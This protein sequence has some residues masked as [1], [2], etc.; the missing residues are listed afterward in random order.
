MH[1][2]IFNVQWDIFNTCH[3]L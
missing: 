2:A 1:H 3:K